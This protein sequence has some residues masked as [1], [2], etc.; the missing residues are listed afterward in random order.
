M[1]WSQGRADGNGLV[2][3][4]R[5]HLGSTDAMILRVR[6]RLIEAARSLHEEGVEPPCL[7]TP[8]VYGQRSGWTILPEANDY[9][10]AMR[11][12]REEFHGA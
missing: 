8:A 3:R 2:D 10:T 5:E 4:S 6:R 11:E 1:K 12:L 9:W 7:D